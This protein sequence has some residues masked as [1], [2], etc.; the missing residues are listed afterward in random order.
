MK[1]KL[2]FPFQRHWKSTGIARCFQSKVTVSF[3][4]SSSTR[5]SPQLYLNPDSWVGHINAIVKPRAECFFFYSPCSVTPW[6]FWVVKLA[7]LQSQPPPPLRPSGHSCP[8]PW[9]VISSCWK[10]DAS[11]HKV[12]SRCLK[13]HNI[14]MQVADWQ[15]GGFHSSAL[16]G[17]ISCQD[18][19]MTKV[20]FFPFHAVWVVTKIPRVKC[21]CAHILFIPSQLS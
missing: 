4:G 14:T 19:H 12:L 20:F 3:C 13:C 1:F 21:S 15:W 2:A 5:A 9:F 16:P 8:P 6:C 18:S 11:Q 7:T 10:L 17:S